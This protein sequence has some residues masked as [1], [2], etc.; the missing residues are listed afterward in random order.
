[1]SGLKGWLRMRLTRDHAAL[2]EARAQRRESEARLAVTQRTVIEPLAMLR[3]ENH[4]AE[5]V[6]GTLRRHQQ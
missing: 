1:M 4:F 5:M 2:A 3:Q 6:M